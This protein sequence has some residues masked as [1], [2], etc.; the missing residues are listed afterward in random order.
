MGWRYLAGL[1]RWG[2]PL[3]VS[4][5]GLASV[6]CSAEDLEWSVW[7]ST[8]SYG[9]YVVCGQVS[10]LVG[11][12]AVAGAPVTVDGSVRCYCGC[13]AG[14]LGVV[15]SEVGWALCPAAFPLCFVCGAACT[16]GEGA[17]VKAGSEWH[18]RCDLCIRV[19][20]CQ[21]RLLAGCLPA[22]CTLVR[23]RWVRSWFRPL[24]GYQ[25]WER[26]SL[27]TWLGTKQSGQSRIEGSSATPLSPIPLMVRRTM[28]AAQLSQWW[29]ISTSAPVTTGVTQC[30]SVM[31]GP[32]ALPGLDQWEAVRL[33]LGGAAVSSSP[34][35]R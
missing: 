34:A 28:R 25:N 30:L 21:W 10:A 33:G 22:V 18:C 7:V 20:L 31:V 24:G 35:P 19:P 2:V 13:S 15:T 14:S 27:T 29:W 32:T 11:W 17:A 23:R 16:G 9:C 5:V 12:H 26:H 3:G 4:P 8:C 1:R 6:A